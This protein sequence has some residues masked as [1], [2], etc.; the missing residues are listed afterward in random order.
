VHEGA[1]PRT[2]GAA[3]FVGFLVAVGVRWIGE[4]SW[5]GRPRLT[6]PGS[7]FW[8]SS[9]RSPSCSPRYPRRHRRSLASQKFLRSARRS[10]CRV[11]AG[12]RID[13]V[14]DPFSGGI[15]LLGILCSGDAVLDGG[16]ANVIN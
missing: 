14:G 9:A 8:G 12:I 7:R 2:G 1:I 11:L 16:F 4:T 15:F 6:K 13:F 10:R 5:A 3:L